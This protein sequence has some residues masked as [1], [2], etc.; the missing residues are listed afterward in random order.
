LARFKWTAD[1]EKR[2]EK[3]AREMEVSLK[4]GQEAFHQLEEVTEQL[5]DQQEQIKVRAQYTIEEARLNWECA[6]DELRRMED[7]KRN[8]RFEAIAASS[9]RGTWFA[10]FVALASL[11]VS[12]VALLKR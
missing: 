2:A 12:L 8:D 6:L 10:A 1:E 3:L 5:D 7:E 11:A 4:K 9:T